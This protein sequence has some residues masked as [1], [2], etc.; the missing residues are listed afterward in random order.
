MDAS[1]S[2]ELV[3][4]IEIDR[5]LVGL[6][7]AN[8]GIS[9]A[10]AVR[11]LLGRWTGPYLRARIDLLDARGDI[12]IDRRDGRLYLYPVCKVDE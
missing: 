7:T 11:R 1:A 3:E 2:T 10:D 6:A 4:L 9:A 8:P 12:H 5:H